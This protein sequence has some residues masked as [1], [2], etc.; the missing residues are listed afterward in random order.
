[1]RSVNLKLENETHD[2][3]IRIHPLV[4][5]RRIED[6][7]SKEMVEVFTESQLLSVDDLLNKLNVA[8]ET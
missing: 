6:N 3:V 7:I 2:L 8:T 5:I 1:M 4:F